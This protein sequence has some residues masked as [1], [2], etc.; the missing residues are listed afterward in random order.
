MALMS[1]LVIIA[2]LALT[3]LGRREVQLDADAVGIVEEDLLAAGARDHLLAE[4][5]L[6][7]LELLAHAADV[8]SGKGDVVEAAGVLELLLVAAHDNAFARLAGPEQ[9]H[10]R[11]AAGIEPVAREA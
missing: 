8:G 2:G 5:H 1:M 11:H 7:G 6:L 4:L 10:G 9:V 3:I